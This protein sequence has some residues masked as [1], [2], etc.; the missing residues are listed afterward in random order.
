LLSVIKEIP[1]PKNW[2]R[3]NENSAAVL[4]IAGEDVS[5]FS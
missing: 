3:Q 1:V 5:R 2:M 4:H